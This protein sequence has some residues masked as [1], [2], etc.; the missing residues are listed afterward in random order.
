MLRTDA[1]ITLLVNNAGHHGFVDLAAVISREELAEI[2]ST[3]KRTAGPVAERPT[4]RLSQ[5]R[6]SSSCYGHVPRVTAC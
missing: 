4:S 2:S 1:S 5:P 6:R 3:Y